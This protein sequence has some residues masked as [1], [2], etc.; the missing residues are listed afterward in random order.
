MSY[1]FKEALDAHFHGTRR[2]RAAMAALTGLLAADAGARSMGRQSYAQYEP[3][4]TARAAVELADALIAELNLSPEQRAE[5]EAREA[6]E[7]R[8]RLL[9]EA[10]DG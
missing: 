3:V 1:P 2:E 4:A 7:R 10:S 8:Q 6:E 9:D 5:R